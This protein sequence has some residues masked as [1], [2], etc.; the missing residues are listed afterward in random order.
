M[1]LTAAM[2]TYT[3]LQEARANRLRMAVEAED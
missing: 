1:L 3:K 2:F